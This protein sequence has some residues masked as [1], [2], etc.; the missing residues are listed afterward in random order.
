MWFGLDFQLETETEPNRSISIKK[1]NQTNPKTRS[2]VW[3][4]VF[5]LGLRFTVWIG[6]VLNTPNQYHYS[7]NIGPPPYPTPLRPRAPN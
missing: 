3:I 7:A 2:L 4:S 1:K 6:S 5:F